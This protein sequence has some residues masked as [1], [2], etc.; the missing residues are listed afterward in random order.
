MVIGDKYVLTD[1]TKVVQ[2]RT[3]HRIKALRDFIHVKAG[4]PGGWIESEYNLS[5]DDDAWVADEACVC[6][7]ARVIDNAQV[8]DHAMV[9]GHALIDNNATVIGKAR[10][11][12]Y[13][14][15]HGNAMITRNACV[16]DNAVVADSAVV[17]DYASVRDSSKV[18]GFTMLNNN[19]D[20]R[21]GAFIASNRDILYIC[22][23]NYCTTHLTFYKT[24]L[25]IAVNGSWEGYMSLRDYVNN[26]CIN[27]DSDTSRL[28]LAA[29]NLAKTYFN[30]EEVDDGNY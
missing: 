24:L 19:M 12:D 25:G 30:L 14:V 21:G 11:L 27:D 17:G 29:Y 22:F 4:K 8:A 18:F 3:L 15:I 13:A 26:L 23:R 7:E 28:Y 6:D 2:G 1:E 5:Q 9:C 10:V 20:I 16:E